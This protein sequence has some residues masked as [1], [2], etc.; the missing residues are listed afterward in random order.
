[1]HAGGATGAFGGIPYGT[2]NAVPGVADASGRCPSLELPMR[3]RSAVLVGET[4]AGVA[5]GVFLWS[6]LRGH[7]T[8]HW[9]V[10]DACGRCHW[11]LRWSSLWGHRR[12]GTHAGVAT[13]AFG[14]HW[15]SQWSHET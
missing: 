14:G 13:G 7:E 8:L 5:A 2:R 1:M 9:V 6:S 12:G 11:D 4:H 15:S 3:P 10:A